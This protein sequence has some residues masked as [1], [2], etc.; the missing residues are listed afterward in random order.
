MNAAGRARVGTGP[1]LIECRTY[2]IGFHNTSDNPNEY[3]DPAEV[4]AERE[5]DP[6]E[7][8]RRYA[9]QRGIWSANKEA[10][11]LERIRKEIDV[12]QRSVES[13]PRPTTNAIFEHVYEFPPPRFQE[14][15]REALELER[16]PGQ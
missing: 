2:R 11:L 7:R 10:T 14:Q 9:T 3:R 13:S 8:L 16:E 5:R 6:I 1:S 4:A 15:A 12:A